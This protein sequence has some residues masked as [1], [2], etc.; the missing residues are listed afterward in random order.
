MIV[1][2]SIPELDEAKALVAS[3]QADGLPYVG[4]KPGTV[5]QIRQV[6][7]IA[8]AVAPTTI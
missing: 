6:V 1:S 4:F 7:A 8:K 3:L 5:A 2:A